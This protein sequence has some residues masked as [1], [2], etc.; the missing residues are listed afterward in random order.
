MPRDRIWIQHIRA[1]HPDIAAWVGEDEKKQIVDSLEFMGYKKMIGPATYEIGPFFVL[2]MVKDL[3]WTVFMEQDDAWLA[4]RKLRDIPL[5]KYEAIK[6]A[7][8]FW[9]AWNESS[10]AD[11]SRSEWLDNGIFSQ[12]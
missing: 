6:V 9:E 10:V 11:R 4:G 8:E 12:Q 3:V 2:E 5:D 1:P 7:D